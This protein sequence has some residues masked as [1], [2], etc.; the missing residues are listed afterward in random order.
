MSFPVRSVGRLLQVFQCDPVHHESGNTVNHEHGA[1]VHLN[2]VS[3]HCNDGRSTRRKPL[4][5]DRLVGVQ[6]FQLVVDC[7]TRVQVS[8][9]GVDFHDDLF[10][11]ACRLKVLPECLRADVVK[12]ANIFEVPFRHFAAQHI[13]V[14][15]DFGCLA[16]N[17]DVPEF[18]CF[19]FQNCSP[20]L[21]FRVFFWLRPTSR[22]HAPAVPH[23][24]P[25]GR[26]SDGLWTVHG[27]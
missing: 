13:A 9:T 1:G 27:C 14:Q 5:D 18:R 12:I 22:S 25:I 7:D 21:R 15:F 8:A 23:W 10:G 16:V 2:L 11:V 17:D 3:C 24:H 26:R 20:L 4:N 19:S 6:R